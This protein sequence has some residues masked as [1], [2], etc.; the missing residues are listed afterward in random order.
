LYKQHLINAKLQNGKRGQKT[1]GEGL[2]WT[3]VP[4]KKRKKKKKKKK[5]KK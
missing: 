1:G 3:V 4:S 5:K 2:H